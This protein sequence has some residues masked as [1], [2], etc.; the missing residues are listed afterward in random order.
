MMKLSEINEMQFGEII[1]NTERDLNLKFDRLIIGMD[2]KT[3]RFKSNKEKKE[4]IESI[5]RY[6][7]YRLKQ[8]LILPKKDILTGLEK[9]N[10]PNRF[11]PRLLEDSD[12]MYFILKDIEKNGFDD[13]NE[14]LKIYLKIIRTSEDSLYLKIKKREMNKKRGEDIIPLYFKL[15]NKKKL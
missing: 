1:D 12:K 14:I 9:A 8:S 5:K 7:D 3:G 2:T 13:L 6:A 4:M 11:N 10:K 15:I